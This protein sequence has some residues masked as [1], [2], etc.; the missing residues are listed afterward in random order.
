VRLIAAVCSRRRRVVAGGLGAVSTAVV[1]LL[2][3][4]GASPTRVQGAS[5]GSP[6]RVLRVGSYHGIRGQFASI[7]AAVDA[8]HPGDWVLVGPGDYHET[9]NRA[10]RQRR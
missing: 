8:A 6:A 5:A 4:A 7:Q 10:G 2:A 9:G 1:A 3:V